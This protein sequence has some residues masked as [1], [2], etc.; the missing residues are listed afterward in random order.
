[1]PAY[2]DSKTGKWY[3]HF[4]STNWKGEVKIVKKRGF[5]TKKE[6]IA[7]EQNYK[8]L[9][10]GGPDMSFDQFVENYKRDVK[11]RLKDSTC[12]NK[13]NI[14][15]KKIL[16]YFRRKK[17]NEI[18][19]ADIMKWQNE[20]I[21]H[22]YTASY[23]KTLHNQLSAM[24]NHAV[25]YYSLS[26]NVAGIVG[27]MGHEKDIKMKFWTLEEY[28]SFIATKTSDPMHYFAFELLYWT[29]IREGELLAL[30]PNDFNFETKTLSITKTYHRSNGVDYITTP[31]TPKSNREILMPDE[32]A[33]ELQVY[34]SLL[35]GLSPT[36]RV[37]SISKHSLLHA[38]ISGCKESGVKRIRIHD[39]RHSHV[40]L[41]IHL[42]FSAVAIADRMGHES[43]DI[44]YRY[45][46]MFPFVQKDMANKLNMLKEV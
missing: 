6:A 36:E 32:L 11:P 9:E 37:F 39:L 13:N 15:D 14:I 7:Y 17:L 18:T 26:K 12:E 33:D 35:Y 21:N 19:T 40:S 46:H 20:M 8:V 16:P 28:N 34:F 1:M 2:K 22:G 41:L 27:N 3:A 43:S 38:M 31:K 10:S 30:T 24:L 4:R 23:L 25:K 5:A 42:G 44:T 29:G 45:A